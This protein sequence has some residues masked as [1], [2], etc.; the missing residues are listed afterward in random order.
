MSGSGSP[1]RGHGSYRLQYTVKE[2]IEGEKGGGNGDF[3]GVWRI[4]GYSGSGST[5][6]P[7]PDPG[8]NN[9]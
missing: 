2:Q 5:M 4:G 1:W 3:F 8:L 9:Y 7:D 6:D